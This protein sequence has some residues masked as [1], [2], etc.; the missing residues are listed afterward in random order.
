MSQ[1]MQT[2]GDIAAGTSAALQNIAMTNSKYLPLHRMKM[3]PIEKDVTDSW[4]ELLVN[5]KAYAQLT[6]GA[7]EI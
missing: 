4:E 2:Q 3:N 7:T 1:M 6:D 5:I